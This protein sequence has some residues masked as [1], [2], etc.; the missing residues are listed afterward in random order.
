[1]PEAAYL[2]RCLLSISEIPF[3]DI[4]FRIDGPLWYRG[5]K[6]V[7][8]DFVCGV[9]ALGQI[10]DFGIWVD[11][12]QVIAAAVDP[13]SG[14]VSSAVDEPRTTVFWVLVFAFKI[15]SVSANVSPQRFVLNTAMMKI[16]KN[17]FNLVLSYRIVDENIVLIYSSIFLFFKLQHQYPPFKKLVKF[18]TITICR[19]NGV[20]FYIS[21]ANRFY[22]QHLLAGLCPWVSLFI[23]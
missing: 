3:C 6:S 22:G 23:Q 8:H 13:G 9:P 20:F 2:L 21:V 12:L 17:F 19:K 1:M 11:T 15:S 10:Y 16:V 14:R 7:R 5:H 18:C 4:S